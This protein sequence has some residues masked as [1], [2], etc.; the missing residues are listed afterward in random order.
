LG[1]WIQWQDG[2]RVCIFPEA[3]ATGTIEMPPW[4]K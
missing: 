3:A 1:S 4:L 2:R